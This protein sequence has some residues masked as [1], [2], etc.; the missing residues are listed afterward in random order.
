VADSLHAGDVRIRFRFVSDLIWSDQDGLHDTDGAVIVDSLGVTDD[1][2]VV[3]AV[4]DFEDE[5]LGSQSADDWEAGVPPPYGDFAGLFP[6]NAYVQE[7]PCN[8]NL[9]CVWAFCTSRKTLA[10]GI[11][12]ACGPFSRDRR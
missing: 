7:D 1:I 4:E 3:L 6:N 8:R 12:P 2:G 5:A 11:S 9:S 10:T